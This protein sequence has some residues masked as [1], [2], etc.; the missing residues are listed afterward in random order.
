MFA[1]PR[2]ATAI[3]AHM[4]LQQRCCARGK[5]FKAARLCNPSA[6]V[7]TLPIFF[8]KIMLGAWVSPVA[9]SAALVFG[10]EQ[11]TN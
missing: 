3:L 7:S 2:C 8:M 6:P 1:D 4:S 5:L 9:K 11:R 10:G